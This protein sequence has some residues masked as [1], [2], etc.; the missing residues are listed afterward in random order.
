MKEAGLGNILLSI[1]DRINIMF[2]FSSLFDV[3]R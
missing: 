1:L 2:V 3:F